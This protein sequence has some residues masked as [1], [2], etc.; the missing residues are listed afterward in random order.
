MKR[1]T[2][3]NVA[4]RVSIGRPRLTWDAI[5]Q[6]DLRVKGVSRYA[7]RYRIANR[8]ATTGR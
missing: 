2:C 7:T 3:K 5:L 4:G 8:D 6:N 1:S